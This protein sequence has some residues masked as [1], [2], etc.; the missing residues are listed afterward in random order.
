[1][2]HRRDFAALLI[3]SLETHRQLTASFG[4]IRCMTRN[5]ILNFWD[6]GTVNKI[7]PAV[8]V[9]LKTGFQCSE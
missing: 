9:F 3:L 1:M 4:V 2:M 6:E 5:A 7:F 8:H